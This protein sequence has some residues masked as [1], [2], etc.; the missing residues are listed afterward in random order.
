[1]KT[2]KDKFGFKHIIVSYGDKTYQYYKNWSF[3]HIEEVL[4]R[5]GATYWE[6]GVNDNEV[7]DIN[8][9]EEEIPENLIQFM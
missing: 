7:L 5:S 4:K 8:K 1:M 2:S 9:T 3:A 6:I